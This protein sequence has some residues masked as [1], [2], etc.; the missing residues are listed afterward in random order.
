MAKSLPE[1]YEKG[2]NNEQDQKF[3]DNFGIINNG[4]YLAGHRIG[5]IRR[6]LW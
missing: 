4:A 5:S 2:D 1:F 6:R 3:N